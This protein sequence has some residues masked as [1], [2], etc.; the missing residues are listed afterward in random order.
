MKDFMKFKGFTGSAELDLDDFSIRG[1]ILFISDLVTYEA[2][3]AKEIK[4]E[5]EA[6]VD[7][8]LETCAALGREPIKPYCGT[9]NVRI[10]PELHQ[11]LAVYSAL[12]EESM[13]NLV[14]VSV[15]RFLE[16][17]EHKAVIHNHFHAAPA[18][19]FTK[20]LT[21]NPED[22]IV[23]IKGTYVSSYN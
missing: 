8:Y 13:N 7:D 4:A 1:K 17:P 10:G 6:A 14:K 9:F 3:S 18:A 16:D 11:R 19:E 12:K 2:D 22:K 21:Y 20:S 23:H 15:R 5:F